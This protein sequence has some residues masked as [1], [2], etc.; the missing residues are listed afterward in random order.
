[1]MHW[2]AT[3]LVKECIVMFGKMHLKVSYNAF[4][5]AVAPDFVSN[6]CPECYTK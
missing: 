6:K 1:M 2:K 4:I 5:M 3:M